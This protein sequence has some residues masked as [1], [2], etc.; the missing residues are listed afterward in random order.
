MK[1]IVLVLTLLA[2]G[3]AASGGELGYFQYQDLQA[4]RAQVESL[5]ADNAQLQKEKTEL[6][7]AVAGL[8]TE[9]D[10]LIQAHAAAQEELRQLTTRYETLD[11]NYQSLQTRYNQSL[12]DRAVEVNQLKR[13]NAQMRQALEQV[14]VQTRNVQ[15]VLQS[16]ANCAPPEIEHGVEAPVDWF[17]WITRI[18]GIL[19]PFL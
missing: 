8:T 2:I 19:G 12:G 3:A 10:Q 9:L 1:A 16:R 5:T 4:T 11:R 13:D 17:T 18:F 15:A 6:E 7:T 14:N